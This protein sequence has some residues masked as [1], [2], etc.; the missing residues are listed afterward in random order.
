MGE[1]QLPPISER[2][3]NNE[4]KG[5]ITIEKISELYKKANEK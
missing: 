5:N 2:L 4:E 1:V 3:K